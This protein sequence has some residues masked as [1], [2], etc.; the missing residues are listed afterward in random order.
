MVQPLKVITNVSEERVVSIFWAEEYEGRDEAFIM[1]RMTNG[2]DEKMWK[3]EVMG[4]VSV[5]PLKSAS[6]TKG[7]KKG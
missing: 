2:N 1:L 4:K 5:G 6:H 3:D 7:P